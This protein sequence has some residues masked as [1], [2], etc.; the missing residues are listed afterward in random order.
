MIAGESVVSVLKLR[1]NEAQEAI[2][3]ANLFKLV[4]ASM[5]TLFLLAALCKVRG[6]AM[7]VHGSSKRPYLRCHR[8][9]R[10]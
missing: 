10:R 4:K 7:D 8:A 9:Y 3:M 5:H 6:S 2:V 1:S